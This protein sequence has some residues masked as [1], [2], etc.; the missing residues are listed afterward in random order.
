M[1][2][3]LAA[4][5]KWILS[6]RHS[7]GQTKCKDYNSGNPIHLPGLPMYP[8]E[9]DRPVVAEEGLRIHGRAIGRVA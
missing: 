4:R 6:I 5:L 2:T 7:S 3:A 8:G 9:F 1:P